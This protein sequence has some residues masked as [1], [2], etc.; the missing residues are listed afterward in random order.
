MKESQGI[1]KYLDLAWELKKKINEVLM[2]IVVG[3]LGTVLKG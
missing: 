1:K 2:S 3:I